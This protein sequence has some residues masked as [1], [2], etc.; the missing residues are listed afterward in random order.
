MVGWSWSGYL[1]KKTH[2]IKDPPEDGCTSSKPLCNV[3]LLLPERAGGRRSAQFPVEPP[4]TS[5]AGA[6][7]SP[8]EVRKV[9]APAPPP[10][11]SHGCG[12]GPGGGVSHWALLGQMKGA[13]QR[14]VPASLHIS[15]FPSEDLVRNSWGHSILGGLPGKG[16]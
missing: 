10:S 6:L 16:Q 12:A 13:F 5:P 14:G 7:P 1:L 15:S 3:F 11:K 4:K 8:H 2:K 9:S